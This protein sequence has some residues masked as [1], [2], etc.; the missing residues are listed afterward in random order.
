MNNETLAPSPTPRHRK[1]VQG[2]RS[3]FCTVLGIQEEQC[4]LQDAIL[5]MLKE[6]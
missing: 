3:L 6:T 1:E 2:R 4:R 5:H